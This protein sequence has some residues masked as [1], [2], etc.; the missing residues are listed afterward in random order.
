MTSFIVSRVLLRYALQHLS[1]NLKIFSFALSLEVH[2]NFAVKNVGFKGDLA[3]E[4][5]KT[6]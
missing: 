3:A 6:L 1:K 5:H 4:M 2:L